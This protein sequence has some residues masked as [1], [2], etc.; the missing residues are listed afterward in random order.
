MVKNDKTE[1]IIMILGDRP[2]FCFQVRDI[3]SGELIVK[4]PY[5]NISRPQPLSQ[6]LLATCQ[7]ANF[8]IFF[9]A[10]AVASVI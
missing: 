10:A 5:H 9:D 2:C 1:F 4:L 6:I 8:F 7:A 3:H